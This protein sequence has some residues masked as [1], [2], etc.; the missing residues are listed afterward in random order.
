MSDSRSSQKTGM[1][2]F[3]NVDRRTWSAICDLNDINVAIAYLVLGSG[4]GRQNNVT[5][6]S[7]KSLKTWTDM[8]WRNAKEA[9]SKLMQQDFVLRGPGD[10]PSARS[11]ILPLGRSFLMSS[12]QILRWSS[13]RRKRS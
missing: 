9:I 1:A 13:R 12:S 3:F 11:T 7:A 2:G 5:R 8:P 10:T 6:W 4:T